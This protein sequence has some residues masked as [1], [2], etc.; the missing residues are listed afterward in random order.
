MCNVT[1]KHIVEQITLKT[2][3]KS[4]LVKVVTQEVLNTIMSELERGHRIELRDFGIFEPVYRSAK[5]AQNPKTLHP[6]RVEER[7]TVRFK[8][9]K[10]MQECVGEGAWAQE[11][12]RLLR[13]ARRVEAGGS[14]VEGSGAAVGGETA[15]RVDPPIVETVMR[16]SEYPKMS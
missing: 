16:D 6:V 12:L 14:S 3:Y 13:E 4:S 2:N 10:K 9:G 8:P 7:Y 15:A 5:M 11:Q 1:K